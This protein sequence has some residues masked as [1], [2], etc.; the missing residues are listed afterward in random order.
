MPDEKGFTSNQVAALLEDLKSQFK[1][2]VEVVVPIHEDVI[3]IKEDMVEVKDRLSSVE[4]RLIAVEI[5]VTG[6]I[7]TI[8]KRLSALE[9]ANK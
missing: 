6:A 8:N 3:K 5:A 2:V 1:A 7:P 4:N 9:A